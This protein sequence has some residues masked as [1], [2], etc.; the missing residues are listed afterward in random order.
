VQ[1]IASAIVDQAQAQLQSEQPTTTPTTGTQPEAAPVVTPQAT[2]LQFDIP[3][4]TSKVKDL[5]VMKDINKW[6]AKAQELNSSPDSQIQIQPEKS[7]PDYHS[8]EVNQEKIQILNKP[9]NSTGNADSEV[10][11][12][13][14]QH[15]N[16]TDDHSKQPDNV[17]SKEE[18]RRQLSAQYEQPTGIICLLCKRKLGTTEKLK[19]HFQLSKLH[20]V[21]KIYFFINNSSF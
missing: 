3:Q 5:R 2:S 16:I 14:V 21:C 8:G 7:K 9:V 18:I 15:T 13:Y 11:N 6:N 20:A 19:L 1:S 10:H 12:Q 17:P 4:K